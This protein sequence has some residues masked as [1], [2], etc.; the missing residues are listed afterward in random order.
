MIAATSC[1]SQLLSLVDRGGFARAVRKHQAERGAKGFSCWDQFVAMM[2]CQLGAAHSLREICGGLATAMGKLTHLGVSQAPTRSTLAY[3]NTHRPWQLYQTVFEELLGQCQALAASKR[4][5][6]RFKNPLRSLDGTVIELCVSV[7]D[8]AH[9]QRTKGAVKLHLQLDHQ[10]YLPCCAVLTDAN[11]SEISIARQMEFAPGTIVVM[12][13]GYLDYTLY[14]RWSSTG[15]YFVTRAHSNMV[16]EVIEKREV[17]NR[18]QVLSDETVRLSSAY[19]KERCT[20][21]LRRVVVYNGEQEREYVFLTNLT[22]LAASTIA[23][24]YK[25]RWQIELFFKA[26]KQNLKIKSFVGTSENAVQVQIWT[27]LIAMLLLK[28]LLLKSTWD[29]SLSNLAAMLRFNLLSYRDLWAWLDS[30]FEVPIAF[31]TTQQ[32]ELIN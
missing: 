14:Q 4:R 27:A 17:T 28:Y 24:I 13:R 18:G 5:R 15:V 9:Y 7:F 29:W 8:W 16:Y 6:F 21:A 20:T 11:T 19:G 2:F 3:A 23:A 26:L 1:F 22:H 10:G 30:P 32:L 31:A 25:E 12:D